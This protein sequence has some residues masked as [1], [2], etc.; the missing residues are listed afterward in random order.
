MHTSKLLYRVDRRRIS[1]I[2]FI[3]EAYEGVAVITT[4]DSAAGIISLAVAPGCEKIAVEV[5]NDLGKAAMI[6]PIDDEGC[7]YQ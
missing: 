2:R 1:L 4:L 7:V 6:Q 3:F 5:M